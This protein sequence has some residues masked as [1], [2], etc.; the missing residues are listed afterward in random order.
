MF[1]RLWV[2][3]NLYLNGENGFQ[4]E[5]FTERYFGVTPENQHPPLWD[6]EKKPGTVKDNGSTGGPGCVVYPAFWVILNSN[7]DCAKN[8]SDKIH[9]VMYLQA[10][11]E[12]FLFMLGLCWILTWTANPDIIDS[13][14]IKDVFGYNNVCVGFDTTPAR[15]FAQ[16]LM[17]L[18]GFYGIRYVTL[19][20]LRADLGRVQAGTEHDPAGL[21]YWFTYITNSLFACTMLLW[22]MLLIALPEGRAFTYHFYIY[23]VFV[24]IMYLTI[25]ANFLEAYIYKEPISRLG[26]VWCVVFGVWT[27]LLLGVGTIGFNG[28]DYDKCPTLDRDELI[29][30]GTYE[31]LCIQDP[32]IP[33]GLMATLDYGWFILLT[34]APWLL[35]DSPP[36]VYTEITTS[37]SESE[38]KV[39]P[40]SPDERPDDEKD[41]DGEDDAVV[42][43]DKVPPQ[44]EENPAPEEEGF[45]VPSGADDVTEFGVGQEEN[46][47]R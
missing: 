10:S 32:T 31:T 3:A 36:I 24:V 29:A 41:N 1:G 42:D 25:F 19:D 9:P 39:H 27:V 14:R 15:Y 22:G 37:D 43:K 34:L 2:V 5:A 23:A 17:A 13:N 16:P 46:T 35:P 45:G 8:G 28:Y 12:A 11:F 4:I 38:S 47:P 20:N 18:Q 7:R 30:N 40:Q 44:P 21:S 6:C 26:A 33:I